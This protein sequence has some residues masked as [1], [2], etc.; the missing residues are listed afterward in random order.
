MWS[1]VGLGLTLNVL[2]FYLGT[3]LTVLNQDFTTVIQNS[4]PPPT[5][6]LYQPLTTSPYST[7][8]IPTIASSSPEAPSYFYMTPP[9]INLFTY[10]ARE[11]LAWFQ[12]GFWQLSFCRKHTLWSLCFDERTKVKFLCVASMEK[13]KSGDEFIFHPFSFMIFSH[14]SRKLEGGE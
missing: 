6:H 3:S 2:M 14:S 1:R 12:Q 13:K 11:S 8:Y 4:F 10:Q 7:S 5:S 9:H